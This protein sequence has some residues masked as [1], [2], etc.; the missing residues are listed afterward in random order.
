MVKSASDRWFT[1]VMYSFLAAVGL[2]VLF[3]LLYVASVSLTPYSEVLKHGGFLIIPKEITFAAYK[4]L[5]KQPYIF[6][7][8]NVT[9][10]ITLVGTLLNLVLTALMAYPLSRKDLPLRGV[11][12]MMVVFTLIFNGGIIPTY[13][14]VQATGLLDSVWAMIIP[15]A[16]W[17]FNLLILKS[18]F[19][20]LP[21]ELFES[22]RI[23]GAHEFRV[24]LQ[25]V[26]PLS[27]PALITVGLFYGVGHWNEFFQAIMYTTKPDL[28]PLQVIVYNLLTRSQGLMD[29]PDEV[30]P[31]MTLQMAAVLYAALPII[32]V[33]PFIQKYLTKGM[34]IGSIKG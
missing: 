9:V 30:I 11:W 8:F 26:V 22:A 20:N 17:S 16:I 33:Y 32:V 7:A 27:V 5:W 3:P 13:L 4:E 15:N 31:T 18:F 14:I 6:Q 25:I 19:E 24:L 29:N 2:S 10:F 12:L 1:I 23:D 34:I 28:K 21:K